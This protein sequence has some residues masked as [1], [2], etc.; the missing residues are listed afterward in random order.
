VL[1]EFA[2]SVEEGILKRNGFSQDPVSLAWQDPVSGQW[3]D[4]DEALRLVK[5]R[6]H[7]ENISAEGLDGAADLE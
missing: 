5:E 6:P 7:S 4:R 3:F 2:V 1:G